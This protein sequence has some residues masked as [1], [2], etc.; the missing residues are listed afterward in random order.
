M[1][2][3]HACVPNVLTM[4]D[5]KHVT[6]IVFLLSVSCLAIANPSLGFSRVTGVNILSEAERSSYLN[7][8]K[9]RKTLALFTFQKRED[10][11]TY[12]LD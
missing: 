1:P 4:V 8:F 2:I 5:Y 3:M 6:M 7:Q 12:N 9:L 10:L 11:G